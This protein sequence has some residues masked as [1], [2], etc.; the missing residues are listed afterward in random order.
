MEEVQKIIKDILFFINN[1]KIDKKEICKN[2][3]LTYPR[4]ARILKDGGKAIDLFEL[5]S[6]CKNYDINK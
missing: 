4:L 3:N 6:Y 1:K 5:H 2:L